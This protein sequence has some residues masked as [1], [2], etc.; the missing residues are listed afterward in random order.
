MDAVQAQQQARIAWQ[1][2]DY[3]AASIGYETAIAAD[4]HTLTNYWYLGMMHLLQDQIDAAQ[5]TWLMAI[6]DADPANLD[7]AGAELGQI[8]LTE[9]QRQ[10]D[11][12]VWFL[13]E[14]LYEQALEFDPAPAAIFFAL[15]RTYA[16]QGRLDEAITAWQTVLELQPD[17]VAAY[18]EQGQVWQKLEQWSAAIAAY[19][20][21]LA[22]Q[23]SWEL[24]YNL[25]RCLAQQQPGAAAALHLNQ[26][27]HLN[28]TFTPIAGDLVPVLLQQGD[29]SG[30]IA[31]LQRAVYSQSD[32]VKQYCA[33]VM[34]RPAQPAL[35]A[36]A[37]FLQALTPPIATL[38]VEL[39][40]AELLVRSGQIQLAIALYEHVS[41]SAPE[42][43]QARLGLSKIQALIDQHR[44]TKAALPT[45]PP[46][47]IYDTTVAW[48]S[49]LG[50]DYQ[51]LDVGSILTLTPPQTTTAE[52]HFS[53]RFP[54]E[55]PLPNTFV[56]TIP[57]GTFWIN[58]Q[59]SSTA[60]LTSDRHLLRDLSPEFPLLSPGHPDHLAR[61]HAL[62][63]ANLPPVQTLDGPIVVLAGLSNDMY[64]HW[65]F[66]VLP[67]LNLIDRSGLSRDAIAG[68]VVSQ[69]W[70]FQ[71]ETLAQ[72]GIPA[73]KILPPEQYPHLQ[74]ECLIVP[75]FPGSPAWMPQWA[76]QWLRQV[77]LVDRPTTA[78]R[79]YISRQQT[80]NRRVINEPV[81]MTVLA[82]LGF[83]CVTLEALTV[84]EQAALF[85]SATVVIAPHGGGLTNLVFCSPGTTVI[86]IFPP[87]FVYPCYWLISNLMN[88]HYHYLIGVAPSGTYIHQLL[89]PN[90]RLEDIFVDL[91]ILR[92]TLQLAGI[93]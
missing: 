84:R 10:F 93:R 57:Q 9:A 77:F 26:A 53:F 80:A 89:Y 51:P 65:L 21:A 50:G 40:L 85:A 60:I 69:H 72:L 17:Y 16:Y 46:T 87:H 11:L 4:P 13:A 37:T 36:N 75:S 3:V 6:A 31:S 81:V 92:D 24:H 33:W 58:P 43:P 83:Q 5:A 63:T 15:G 44:Q 82:Q 29:W 67:R 61:S 12:G 20:Q 86:E 2:G 76:C 45:H 18:W 30:A 25:G 1:R 71:Q 74:A 38:T 48:S 14:R 91:N 90:A 88:L 28:P 54:R 19:T 62:F 55:M 39:A 47:G 42:P 7:V 79:L 49:A 73:H 34:V 35:T 66:D 64:F 78:T 59:Q 56:V 23:P 68:F 22:L 52:I 32:W 27:L 8:L 41:Q 70:P